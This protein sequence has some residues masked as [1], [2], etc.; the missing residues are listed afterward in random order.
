TRIAP[1][2]SALSRRRRGVAQESVPA[3]RPRRTMPAEPGVIPPQG[4]AQMRQSL[5]A[6]VRLRPE[7]LRA[8]SAVAGASVLAVRGPL[9]TD[10]VG[11]GNPGRSPA[12]A[13][14][15]LAGGGFQ[16]LEI[17]GQYDPNAQARID[18]VSDEYPLAARPMLASGL[19]KLP[20]AP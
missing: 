7:L 15:L 19:R 1:A 13:E 5:Q 11:A 16:L 2:R 9:G 20:F 18:P 12:T 17:N 4:L 10:F 8:G 14:S 3:Y 6:G